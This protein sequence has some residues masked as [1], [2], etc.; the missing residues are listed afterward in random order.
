MKL[1]WKIYC[2][3]LKKKHADRLIHQYKDYGAKPGQLVKT[4]GGRIL[5]YLGDNAYIKTRK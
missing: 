4:D 3:Y 5:R 1:F 2:Q